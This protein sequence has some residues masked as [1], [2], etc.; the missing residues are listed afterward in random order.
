WNR[1]NI[2]RAMQS[3][4]MKRVMLKKPIPVLFFYTTAYVDQNDEVAF[5]RDIYGHDTVLREALKNASDLSDQLLFISK[6][7]NSTEPVE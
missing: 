2:E 4:K 7:T 6:N 3:P 1:E 5:Y